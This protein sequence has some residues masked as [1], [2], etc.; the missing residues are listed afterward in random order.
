[1]SNQQRPL[2]SLHGGPNSRVTVEMHPQS[3]FR[4]SFL[5]IFFFRSHLG[6]YA[7]RS[8]ECVAKLQPQ[9]VLPAVQTPTAT[10]GASWKNSYLQFVRLSLPL[11]SA[12]A[13][14]KR[15]SEKVRLRLRSLR[16]ADRV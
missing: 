14:A 11:A 9:G 16:G 15:R 3:Y 5:F 2:R 7:R 12:D 13:L 8:C 1:Q 4:M 6:R 10:W